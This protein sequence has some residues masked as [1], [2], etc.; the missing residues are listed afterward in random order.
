MTL[1]GGV[2]LPTDVAERSDHVGWSSRPLFDARGRIQSPIVAKSW[3]TWEPDEP[4]SLE[5]VLWDEGPWFDDIDPDA[6]DLAATAALGSARWDA[7]LRTAVG[8]VSAGNVHGGTPWADVSHVEV[9][10]VV[11]DLHGRKHLVPLPVWSRGE[12]VVRRF[13]DPTGTQGDLQWVGFDLSDPDDPVM[14]ECAA[15]RPGPGFRE[16]FARAVV[17]WHLADLWDATPRGITAV[18]LPLLA[19]TYRHEQLDAGEIDCVIF[20]GAAW[21]SPNR[22]MS[23]ARGTDGLYPD[24]PIYAGTRLVL[25]PSWEPDPRLG[26]LHPH[27]QTLVDAMKGKPGRGKGLMIGDRSDP[28]AGS[29]LRSPMDPRVTIRDLGIRHRHLRV[30][31]A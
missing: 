17:C 12:G 4:P 7:P 13:G 24:A 2:P 1:P 16:W 3:S 11:Y 15:L 20:V 21:Y 26:E 22:I 19:G 28:K 29:A 23:P 18:N 6:V 9:P 27:E 31:A 8:T 14:W 5:D 10:T 25:D 30:L